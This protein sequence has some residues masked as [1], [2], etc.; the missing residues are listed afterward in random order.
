MQTKEE[1]EVRKVLEKKIPDKER[2]NLSISLFYLS[3]ASTSVIIHQ[4][5]CARSK[6]YKTM[7][8]DCTVFYKHPSRMI[9]MQI[10]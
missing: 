5:N 1:K 6:F 2:A 10:K 4:K 8:M 7:D 9:V 3:K